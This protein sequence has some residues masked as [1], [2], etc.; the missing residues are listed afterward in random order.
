MSELD[1][2]YKICIICD[3][4]HNKCNCDSKLKHIIEW[5]NEGADDKKH[6]ECVI[7]NIIQPYGRGYN[8]AL[9]DIFRKTIEISKSASPNSKSVVGK[10]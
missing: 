7:N 3:K 10:T 1:F 2:K 6:E 9:F 8:D 5:I 4:K